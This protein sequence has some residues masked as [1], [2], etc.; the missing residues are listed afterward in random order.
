M[1]EEKEFNDKYK[2]NPLNLL[3]QCNYCNSSHPRYKLHPYHQKAFPESKY[4]KFKQC[5]PGCVVISNDTFNEET[6][7][8][9]EKKQ[10]VSLT[11]D[12]SCVAYDAPTSHDPSS[13]SR[14]QSTSKLSSHK[15]SPSP[16]SQQTH[17]LNKGRFLVF[18][19]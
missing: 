10:N 19:I 14:T 2:K 3:R 7:L 18:Y 12:T 6:H 4:L 15:T 8:T 5:L 9:N 17:C 1:L 16:N 13:T 11:N